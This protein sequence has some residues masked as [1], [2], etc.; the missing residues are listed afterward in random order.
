MA[1][2]M[3]IV[4]TSASTTTYT[5]YYA[6]AFSALA[7]VFLSRVSRSCSFVHHLSIGFVRSESPS[8]SSSE[9]MS[10]EPS[11]SGRISERRPPKIEQLPIIQNGASS[12]F[13]AGPTNS[14]I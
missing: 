5:Y 10:G 14:A 1:T 8:S 6:F 11:V 9:S 7:F 13:S 2:A 4:M 3:S 12:E